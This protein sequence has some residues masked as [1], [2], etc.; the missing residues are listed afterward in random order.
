MDTNERRCK[1]A[2]KALKAGGYDN[3]KINLETDIIDLIADL[4]HLACS[5]KIDANKIKRCAAM[6]LEAERH[7]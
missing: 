7:Q 5:S 6:H 1:K 2:R 4:L 3:G